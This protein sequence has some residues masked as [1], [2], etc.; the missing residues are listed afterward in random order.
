[1]K[2]I[3]SN[4]I[5]F[6]FLISSY[7][8]SA[9]SDFY[10]YSYV[11][12]EDKSELKLRFAKSSVNKY[13]GWKYNQNRAAN[14]SLW[15]PSL[16]DASSPN[17][18][19]STKEEQKKAK[20]KPNESDRKVILQLGGISGNYLKDPMSLIQGKE[21]SKCKKQQSFDKYVKEGTVGILEHYK[22]V[23]NRSPANHLYLLSKPQKGIGCIKC[24]GATC[25]LFGI[26]DLGIEYIATEGFK[27]SEMKVE[28]LEFHKRINEY[29][30]TKK[31]GQ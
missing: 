5:K 13:P 12:E 24:N 27:E 17:V 29:I 9:S 15:Y 18:W 16:T 3:T 22:S 30:K 25:Q 14:V 21:I 1:M 4:I 23:G 19:M 2:K 7:Y 26:S 20:I 10:E 8:A 11:N 6:L 31:I 28:V